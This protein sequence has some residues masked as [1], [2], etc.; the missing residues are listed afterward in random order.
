MY[1][2]FIFLYLDSTAM[3]VVREGGK[4]AVPPLKNSLPPRKIETP[5]FKF[6]KEKTPMSH[7]GRV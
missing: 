2:I 1:N 7:G 3:G 6:Q 4:G 5:L